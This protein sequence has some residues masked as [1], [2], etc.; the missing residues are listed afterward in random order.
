MSW[1]TQIVSAELHRETGD[2]TGDGYV[3][4]L[5]PATCQAVPWLRVPLR[6][7]KCTKNKGQVKHALILSH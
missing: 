6:G 2:E 4:V 7:G 5:Q 3:S 1:G